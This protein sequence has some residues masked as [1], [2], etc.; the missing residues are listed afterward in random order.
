[1]IVGYARTQYDS[2]RYAY[3]RSGTER[4]KFVWRHSIPNRPDLP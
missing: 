3:Y 2:N 4:S 1:M